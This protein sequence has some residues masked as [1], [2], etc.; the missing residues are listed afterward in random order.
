MLTLARAA[1]AVGGTL[2]AYDILEHA[3][4]LYGPRAQVPL[5]GQTREARALMVSQFV[6]CLRLSV[7]RTHDLERAL[8]AELHAA[9]D[10]FQVVAIRDAISVIKARNHIGQ[11]AKTLGLGWADGMRL[12]SVISEF[13]R[14]A[15]AN[16]GGLLSTRVHSDRA[17]LELKL[18]LRDSPPDLTV[19]RSLGPEAPVDVR[20]DGADL[21]IELMLRARAQSGAA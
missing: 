2:V 10:G 16:G 3:L 8:L 14:Y 21:V 17:E 6:R 7:P 15:A 20:H 13:V 19:L 4:E 18:H 5:D 9:P 12:E 11:I 1:R